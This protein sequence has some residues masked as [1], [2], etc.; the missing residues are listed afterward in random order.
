M[1]PDESPREKETVQVLI[2]TLFPKGRYG[3]IR[4]A[5][6]WQMTHLEKDGGMVD[7][8]TGQKYRFLGNVLGTLLATKA[9]LFPLSP[10]RAEPDA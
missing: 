9:L 2:L 1:R 10:I 5:L 8:T 7:F 4:A 6:K 3:Q